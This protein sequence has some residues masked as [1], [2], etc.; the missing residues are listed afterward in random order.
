M[1][2]TPEEHAIYAVLLQ[3]KTSPSKRWTFSMI[4][5]GAETQMGGPIP[6]ETVWKVLHRLESSQTIEWVD[7]TKFQV[8]QPDINYINTTR[9]KDGEVISW[10]VDE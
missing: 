1:T 10:E 3:T 4:K 8:K 6:D 5:R 2:T 9:N 7:D